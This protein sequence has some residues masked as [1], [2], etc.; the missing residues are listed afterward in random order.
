M[1]FLLRQESFSIGAE[2]IDFPLGVLK[3]IF[4]STS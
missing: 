2:A 3:V 4:Y 1:L